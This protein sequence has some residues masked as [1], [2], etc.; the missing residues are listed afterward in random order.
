MTSH[1]MRDFRDALR[2]GKAK[3]Q[4]DARAA[5]GTPDIWPA[6]PAERAADR[7][8][9][10]ARARPEWPRPRPWWIGALFLLAAFCAG[11]AAALLLR[12]WA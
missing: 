7:L 4:A 11:A 2:D 3:L 8:L 1:P 5:F 10:K 6:D 9:R 12:G